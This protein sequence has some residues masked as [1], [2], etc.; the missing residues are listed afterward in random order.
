[1]SVLSSSF[2]SFGSSGVVRYMPIALYFF[3]ELDWD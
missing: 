2:M 3:D 1:M